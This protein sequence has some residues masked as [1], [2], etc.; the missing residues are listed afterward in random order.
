[1]AWVILVAL[2]ALGAALIRK[3]PDPAPRL[4]DSDDPA[5]VEPVPLH[6]W[7]PVEEEGA[8]RRR[9]GPEEG[10]APPVAARRL[11]ALPPRTARTRKAGRGR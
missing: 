1:M 9:R 4:A 6:A 10:A 2:A 5:P 3:L 7:D 8:D 11:R